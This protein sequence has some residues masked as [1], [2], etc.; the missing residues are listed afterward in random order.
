MNKSG[1]GVFT[2]PRLF[3]CPAAEKLDLE[4]GGGSLAA[5]ILKQ[6]R[7]NYQSP[8]GMGDFLSFAYSVLSACMG[9]SREARQ[10]GTMKAAAATSSS[11]TA[12]AAKTAGSS[13]CVP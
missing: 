10:A 6:G 12:T 5:K 13:G 11:V 7:K 2:L 1:A 3:F 4:G 9:S 8:T